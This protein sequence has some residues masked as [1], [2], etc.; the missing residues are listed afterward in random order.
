MRK[1]ILT[2]AQV[3]KLIDGV[4]L[5]ESILK[6][7][8]DVYNLEGLAEILSRTGYDELILLEMLKELYRN[9]G[10]EEIIKTFKK[11][12]G[13]DIENVAKGRY[14]FKLS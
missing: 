7:S 3:R 6:E 5:Q 10:D 11:S 12:T 14:V 4:V 13:I 2:E 9:G 8:H 1:Y